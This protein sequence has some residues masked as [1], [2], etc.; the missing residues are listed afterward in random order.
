MRLLYKETQSIKAVVVV[1]RKIE[2]HPGSK[3]GS[4][5]INMANIQKFK[6][7]RACCSVAHDALFRDNP[8]QVKVIEVR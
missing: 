2:I 8:E 6:G 7:F 4:A 5:S 3:Q 1:S